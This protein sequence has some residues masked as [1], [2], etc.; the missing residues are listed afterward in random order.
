MFWRH[1]NIGSLLFAFFVLMQVYA[2]PP[3]P[4]EPLPINGAVYYL[5]VAGIL[6]GIKKIRK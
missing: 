1:K 5:L 6:Y 4:G 2:P 3:P